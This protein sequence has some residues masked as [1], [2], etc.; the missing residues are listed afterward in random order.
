MKVVITDHRFPNIDQE[1]RAISEMGWNLV[2]GQAATEDE[3]VALCEDANGVLAGRARLSKKVI[4]EMK[5]CRIIVRYGIG[6][7]TIDIAAASAQGIM[8]ANVPDYCIDEV[9]DHALALLLLM[10]RQIIAAMALAG[11]QPWS[12]ATMPALHRLRGQVCGLFGFGRIGS[13]LARKVLPLGMRVVVHDPYLPEKRAA[14]GG[15]ELCS[16]DELLKRSDYISLHAPLTSETHHR[17]GEA[18]F[19]RMKPTA[20]IINAARGELIDQDALLAALDSGKIAGAGLD[21]L[22][23]TAATASVINHPKIILTPHS[24][25]LSEEA[26]TTLQASAVAQVIAGLKGEKPY[27]LITPA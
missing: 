25:W 18:A 24:A 1:T 8:V 12:I 13:L 3:L 21:V 27:G 6:V 19:A 23:S 14:D 17:F 15:V 2:V 4:A 9:S 5:R 22:D 20:A 7:E 16:F 10:S 11:R 26:R